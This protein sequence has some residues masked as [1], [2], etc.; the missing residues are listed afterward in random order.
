VSKEAEA[1]SGLLSIACTILAAACAP[2]GWGFTVFLSL[3]V[4][5]PNS[6]VR[7]RKD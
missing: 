4:L 3:C 6:S 2:D 5:M 1:V 7:I